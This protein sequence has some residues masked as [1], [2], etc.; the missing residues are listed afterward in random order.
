[1]RPRAR[2]TLGYERTAAVTP[3]RQSHVFSDASE[4]K[5]S[6]NLK[7]RQRNT[8]TAQSYLTF[9]PG[10]FLN[11]LDAALSIFFRPAPGL[12]S[13]L[14][15]AIPNQADFFVPV[16]IKLITSV[17]SRLYLPMEPIG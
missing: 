8:L 7:Q 14:S 16:M 1:M 12:L 15:L 13:M 2:T 17:P 11:R 6:H 9:L 10:Y 4:A 5:N 3:F